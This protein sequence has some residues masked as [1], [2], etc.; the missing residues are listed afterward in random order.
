[1]MDRRGF[2]GGILALGAAPAIVRAESIMR[3]SP[4]IVMP[5]AAQI[6]AAACARLGLFDC[7]VPISPATALSAAV[8]D[9]K[10]DSSSSFY[11]YRGSVW[12][13]QDGMP[14]YKLSA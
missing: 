9:W 2:L 4:Q 10:I 14:D 11:M 7:H 5:T 12:A 6:I 3:I 13:A 1:M 8:E